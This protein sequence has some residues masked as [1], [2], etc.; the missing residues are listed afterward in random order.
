M[1]VQARL[2]LIK[3]VVGDKDQRFDNPSGSHH[4]S[5]VY[6]Q[7]MEFMSLVIDPISQLRTEFY[8]LF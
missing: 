1:I 6:R 4:Q 8:W 7:L 5:Q 2:I 3:V